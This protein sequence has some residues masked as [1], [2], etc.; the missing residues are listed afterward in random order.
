MKT[1]RPY[2]QEAV[3]SAFEHLIKG[4]APLLINASVGAGKSLIIAD[5]LMKFQ[6]L[7][8]RVLC[9]TNNAE[10][11]RNNAATFKEQ[12]GEPS[13]YCA[14]LLSK[15]CSKNI[16]FGSPVTVANAIK[17]E[18][19]ISSIKFSLIV[20]DEAHGI[21]FNKKDSSYMRILSHYKALYPQMRVLGL[22]GTPFRGKGI[23]IV[24]KDQFFKNQACDISASWLIERGYLSK[25]YFGAPENKSI[26]FSGVTIN[27][28]GQFNGKELQEA[29]S[30]SGRLTASIM[31]EVVSLVDSKRNG[32]FIFA[33]TKAHCQE[34]YAALPPDTTAII[35]GDTPQQERIKILDAARNGFIKYLIN[36]N[37]LTVGID[38]PNFDTVV[39]VRP[40]ES[41]VLYTQAIGRGLRLHAAKESCLILDYAGNLE[42]HGD[43]DNPIINEAI[44]PKAGQEE[45]YVIPCYTCNTLNKVFARRCIG[46][47]NN[48]RCSYYFDFKECPH[49]S[50]QND[51][52]ARQCRS[53]KGE[54][55]DPNAKLKKRADK[56]ILIDFEVLQA[57]YIISSANNGG[58]VFR[59]YYNL[60]NNRIVSEQYYLVSD[61]AKRTFYHSFVKKHFKEASKVHRC[62]N[63]VRGMQF[64]VSK[65]DIMT[66]EKV[67][68]WASPEGLKIKKKVFNMEVN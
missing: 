7:E 22:T 3:N 33:S 26:D 39:F 47:P 66:P 55:I 16:V 25:P 38:V 9:L 62:L 6:R 51:I 45:D 5:I 20:V 15:D 31:R 11:V 54:I 28:M 34:C 68:C 29:V 21:N 67:T 8:K 50:V 1:L 63:S 13:I 43:I 41:L 17:N 56:P 57:K 42:R 2:Q 46:T 10:L 60:S 58:A 24:G 61:I 53:C 48:Q 4:D 23:S 35:T 59:A 19:D 52:T 44:K 14:A 27:G 64:A 37:V 32:A 40:T 36:I 49:C 18:A 30:K 12:G 65:L